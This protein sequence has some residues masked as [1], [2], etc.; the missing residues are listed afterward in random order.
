MFA[1]QRECSVYVPIQG[2]ATGS[3]AV[4]HREFLMASGEMS[5]SEFTTFLT[6]VCSLLALNSVDGS[7]HFVCIDWRHMMELQ[8][9]GQQAYSELK[10][11]CIWV[12]ENAGMGSL[13]RSQHEM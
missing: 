1:R 3:G 4:H 6:D 13:Y 10:N 7:I 11:V 5:S 2:H 9:A 12:K 8:T